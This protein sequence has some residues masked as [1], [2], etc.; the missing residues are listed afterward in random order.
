MN[1]DL[2][3]FWA[4]IAPSLQ[5]ELGLGDSTL[6]DIE[7]EL[8]KAPKVPLTEGEIASIVSYAT[9]K[10][11]HL[12]LHES[13]HSEA[14]AEDVECLES[15]LIALNRNRGDDDPEVDAE[16]D[17]LRKKALEEDDKNEEKDDSC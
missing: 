8:A 10:T 5:Q 9:G 17:R 7:A 11:D 4:R 6:A 1:D 13:G 3:L 15:E 14:N 16:I 12:P 2:D